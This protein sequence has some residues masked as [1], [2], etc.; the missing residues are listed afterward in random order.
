VWAY[1][2]V[3][4]VPQMQL[5]FAFLEAGAVSVKATIATLFKNVMDVSPRPAPKAGNSPFP[6]ARALT[7]LRCCPLQFVVGSIFYLAFGYAFSFGTASNSNKFI[8]STYVPLRSR[9]AAAGSCEQIRYM[10]RGFFLQGVSSCEYPLVF[11]QMAFA[12]TATTST[13]PHR[14]HRSRR[15]PPSTHH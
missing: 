5:G 13:H 12:A 11:F 6:Q 7:R 10:T 1:S 4:F 9:Q 8:G 14:H 15:A 2:L 3:I